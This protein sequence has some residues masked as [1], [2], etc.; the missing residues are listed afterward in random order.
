MLSRTAE[1]FFWNG[2]YIE[3]AEYRARYATVQ[4][5]LF[6][7]STDLEDPTPIWERYLSS[8]GE[9][10]RYHDLYT[11]LDTQSVL[12]FLTLNKSN[13]SSILNLVSA[14]REN[15]RSIQDQLSSEVWHHVNAF[16]LSLKDCTPQDLWRS[17][18]QW[19]NHIQHT[20]HTLYGV[21]ASTMLHDQGWCFYRLGQNTER[22]SHTARLLAHPILLRAAPEPSA[23]S[24]FHQCIAILKSASAYEAYRKVYR[25]DVV[26]AKIVD[27][28]LFHD[29]FP[30]SVRFC[31]NTIRQL[32]T[33]LAS[34]PQKGPTQLTQRLVGQLAADMEFA[35]LDEIYKMGLATFLGELVDRLDDL[36]T[37]ITKTFFRAGEALDLAPPE[38]RRR[39][40]VV[41]HRSEPSLQK[42][43]AVLAIRHQFT[44][45]Y[46][47]PVSG[48]RT[49]MRLAPPQHYGPQRRLDIRWHMEPSAD[50]RHYTDAFGNLVWQLE[51][52][53]IEQV[54]DCLVE[55]RVQKSALYLTDGGLALQGVSTQESDC[56]VEPVEFARLTSLVDSSDTLLR[57]AKRVQGRG[58]SPVELVESFLHQIHAHMRYE[59]GRTHVGTKAS[60]AFALAHGV[61]QDYAHIMLSLCRLVKLPARY[62]SG[63]LPGEGLMHAW[64]EVLLSISSQD[65]PL[66]IAYDPTHE[67]RCDER[68]VTVAVGRDYQ[69]IAPTSGY[70]TGG[71]NNSLKVGVSVVMEAHGPAEHWL[72]FSAPAQRAPN[73]ASEAQQQ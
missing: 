50:Y 36:S 19:L 70:Y 52:P 53:Q 26:P 17:P 24:E 3:R 73:P 1:D 35:T 22:A 4:Y 18:H 8:V 16:Y 44:Y 10:D 48:V 66:W 72:G 13:P 20:C 32:M 65:T 51:H 34:T 71:A 43:N 58:A 15:A 30:R 39:R 29:R 47:S 9:L 12:E 2:R 63:Y 28:L 37:A 60:E 59:P 64:V 42:L 69:D 7:E 46:D 62:V 55:M 33:R 57:L 68:Y 45:S 40:K 56:T 61:C 23:L 25:S 38:P 5:H 11:S 21:I 49:L 67:R 41:L 31:T 14:A 6:L 27:F 54:L